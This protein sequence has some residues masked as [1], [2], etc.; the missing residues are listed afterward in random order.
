MDKA[1]TGMLVGAACVAA[2]AGAGLWPL[3][4]GGAAAGGLLG[5]IG[6]EIAILLALLPVAGGYWLWRRQPRKAACACPPDGGCQTGDACD[7]PRLKG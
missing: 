1:K 4:L 2:C 5:W 6:G 3:V 7:V